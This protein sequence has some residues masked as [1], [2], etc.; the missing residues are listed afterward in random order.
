MSDLRLILKQPAYWL[1]MLF[2]AL[3]IGGWLGANHVNVFITQGHIELVFLPWVL[4]TS[5]FWTS[6]I[7]MKYVK[8]KQNKEWN[9]D[10][11][12]PPPRD[13]SALDA[14]AAKAGE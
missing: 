5:P 3:G 13:Q 12:Q 10:D 14:T 7:L 6:L 2:A 4:I 11:Y 9:L 1:L 8:W